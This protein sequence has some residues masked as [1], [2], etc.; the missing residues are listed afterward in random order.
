MNSTYSNKIEKE[1]TIEDLKKISERWYKKEERELPK[2]VS[3]FTKIM[4][5]FGWH[6]KYE[7]II[8][9]KEKMIHHWYKRIY[10]DLGGSINNYNI[11]SMFGLDNFKVK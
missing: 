9:D 7:V 4:N 5:K 3:W 1:F 8:I 10:S 11:H 6:R 2:G